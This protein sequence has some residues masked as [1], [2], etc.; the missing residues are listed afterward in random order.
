MPPPQLAAA[1]ALLAKPPEVDL[2]VSPRL[3]FHVVPASAARHGIT[4]SL[5][6]DAR[7]ITATIVLPAA[8]FATDEE[9]PVLQP[10][11]APGRAPARHESPTAARPPVPGRRRAARSTRDVRPGPRVRHGADAGAG[12][13]WHCRA[14]RSS[15]PSRR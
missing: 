10:G 6:T 14:V 4:V 13:S 11:T 1:N 9:Q 7:P 2:S 15:A 12:R 3:G 5:S 8:L